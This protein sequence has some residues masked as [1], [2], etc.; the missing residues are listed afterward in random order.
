MITKIKFLAN[1]IIGGVKAFSGYYNTHYRQKKWTHIALEQFYSGQNYSWGKSIEDEDRLGDYVKI[2]DQFLL[3]NIIGKSVLE[4]GCL[5]GKWSQYIVPFA[6]HSALADLSKEIMPV[7]QA[8]LEKAGGVFTFYET[9]GYELNGIGDHTIDFIFSM[10]TLVRVNKRF[11]RQYFE[12]FKRVLKKDGKML[13]HLPCSASSFSVQKNF[14]RLHPDEITEMMI[15]NDFKE[16][17]FDFSTI[18][19]GVL[20]KYGF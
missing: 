15:S 2:K 1:P 5:D 12:H 19:H 4:I 14:V 18:N 9:K 10:D 20:L 11:L 8:R 7:L 16:F 17:T 3:P 13:I 6:S